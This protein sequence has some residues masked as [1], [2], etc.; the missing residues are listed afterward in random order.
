MNDKAEEFS[1]AL[2]KYKK[3]NANVLLPSTRIEGLSDWHEP[4]IDQVSL[5][6]DPEDGD[7]YV[8]QQGNRNNATKYAITKQ[9]LMKLS[10][11]AGIMWHPT[12]CHRT[13]DRRDRNYVS[14]QAVGGVRKADG[15]PIF[16][17]AE[18][19]LDFDVIQ[20]ELEEQYRNKADGYEKDPDKYGW[21]HNMS[22]EAQEAYIQKCIRRDLLQKRKHK[23]KLA[24]SGA[25]NRVVRS[26]LG[27][28]STYK[29][30]ELEKPF[31]M[32]RIVIK[33]DFNDKDVRQAMITAS[34]KSITGVYGGDVDFPHSDFSKEHEIIEIPPDDDPDPEPEEPPEVPPE[35]DQDSAERDFLDADKEVQMDTLRSMAKQLKKEF[36][37]FKDDPACEGFKRIDFYR[38]LKERIDD[39][40]IPF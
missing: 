1:K 4:V 27:L 39:D 34:I 9:G 6:S 17:K 24:E 23:M 35:D 3:Q 31:V 38:Y 19:D 32:A 2:E 33:P 37:E 36:K 20:D 10:A 14:F 26:L 13:D 11:C 12:E 18:Y 8:Q 25:M 22:D 21:W 5:S 30:T 15:T 16:V 28:K 40:S 29:K 7:V